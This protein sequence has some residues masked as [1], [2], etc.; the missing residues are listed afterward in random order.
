[1]T[2]PSFQ[3]PRQATLVPVS[4]IKLGERARETYEDIDSLAESIQK[5]GLI[6]PPTVDENNNLIAGGRR[7]M[8]MTQVL[9]CEYI[10]VVHREEIDQITLRELE[11]EENLRRQDMTWQEKC[12]A[13]ATLHQLRI[14]SN[15]L[16]GRTWRMQDTGALLGVTHAHVSHILVIAKLIKQGDEEI[17]EQPNLSAAW[18]VVLKRKEDEANKV[19][20][21]RFGMVQTGL[22]FSGESGPLVN[23]DIDTS[24]YFPQPTGEGTRVENAGEQVTIQFSSRF[25]L[26]DSVRDI[27]PSL[28]DESIDHCVT[29]PPYA[30]DMDNLD[31]FVN[32]DKVKDEHDVQ[33]N[34]EVF[35]LLFPQ[36]ARVLR[37]DG[38]F[39][40]WFDLVHWQRLCDL[41]TKHGFDYQRWPLVWVKKHPCRNSS[42]N[43]N[44]TKATEFAFVCRK[45]KATIIKPS[46]TN[47]IE[48]DGELERKLYSNPFAKPFACWEFILKHIAVPGQTIL[49]P[50]AGQMSCARACINLNLVPLSIEKKLDHYNLGTNMIR[51]LLTEMHGPNTVFI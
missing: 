38:F 33:E 26:G 11:L 14:N 46:I 19:L 18:N 49:D 44:F 50:F 28:P 31:T 10:P 17:I 8:A 13:I 9:N 25:I 32:L 37:P 29:D 30:I 39:V 20:A 6:H 24:S 47:Y 48:A 35:D 1:M 51:S 21:Q 43:K 12:K 15:H 40:L 36:I 5:L 41:A 16:E 23:M 22:K 42:P 7:F 4:E 27:L 2:S 34:L 45:R 3:Y